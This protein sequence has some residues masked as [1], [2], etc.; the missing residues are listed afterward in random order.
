LA[1]ALQAERAGAQAAESLSR[2]RRQFK[3]GELTPAEWHDFRDELTAEQAAANAEAERLR[4][5][6]AAATIPPEAPVHRDLADLRAEIIGNASV[7]QV[8]AALLR[9]FECFHLTPAD[10]V[11]SPDVA[12]DTVL[13]NIWIGAY[14]VWP[15]ARPQV[16]AD[17]DETMAPV[18]RR[19]PLHG[20]RSSE[21]DALPLHYPE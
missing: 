17:I 6:E 3:A 16:V 20:S 21:H 12:D 10:D 15:Q 8:R 14:E 11:S 18:L 4:D 1:R 19:T 9:T 7:E 2:I 13:D 5:Q